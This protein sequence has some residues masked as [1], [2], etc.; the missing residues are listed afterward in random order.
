MRTNRSILSFLFSTRATKSIA[1]PRASALRFEPLET[2]ELLDAS[3]VISP[4]QPELICVASL[5][6]Q[7]YAPIDLS[8]VA[9]AEDYAASNATSGQT[10]TVTSTSAGATQGS[11]RYALNNAQDGDTITFASSLKGKTIKLTGTEFSVTKSV[12]IDASALYD[13]ETNT[14]GV[15]IDA[16]G[17]SRAFS[18]GAEVDEVTFKGLTVTN[19]YVLGNGGGVYSLAKESNFVNCVVKDNVAKT[20]SFVD[21]VS[22]ER[23]YAPGWGGGLY[24]TGTANVTNCIVIGNSCVGSERAGDQLGGGIMCDYYFIEGGDGSDWG[25]A[26]VTL[27]NSVIAGNKSG[28]GGAIYS[29][30]QKVRLVHCTISGNMS[31]VDDDAM[32][33]LDDD[34]EPILGSFGFTAVYPG[35]GY[36]IESSI[37][38]Q[39][40][41]GNLYDFSGEESGGYGGEDLSIERTVTN[42]VI[43]DDPSFVE[44]PVFIDGALTNLSTLDLHLS[45]SS[46][47]YSG[48]DGDYVG[49]YES[50]APTETETPS[51]VV[52]TALDVVD[53]TD[54]LVS[55]REAVEVYAN[56]GDT[57]TFDTSLAGGTI[58]LDGT[59]LTINKDLTVD[60]SALWN[61]EERT[62]GITISGASKS[63]VF[64]V[65]DA[66]HVAFVALTITN[67]R[68]SE[69]GGGVYIPTA[70]ASFAKCVISDSIASSAGGGV[71]LTGSSTFKDCTIVGNESWLDYG[72]GVY[73]TGVS[74]F[75][76]CVILANEAPY[77]GGGAYL[78]RPASFTNCTI[79]GNSCDY[80]LGGGVQLIDGGTFTRSIVALNYG[81]DVGGAYTQVGASYTNE[82]SVIAENPMFQVAPIIIGRKLF[83]GWGDPTHV[84]NRS[85]IDLNLATYS[86]YV[87]YL[88]DGYVG[89]YEF[90]GIKSDRPDFHI[91]TTLDDEFDL[92]NDVVSLREA[93]YMT[94]EDVEIVFAEGLSGVIKL[95]SEL[96][97]YSA[98]IDGDNRITLDGQSCSRVISSWGALKLRNMT[99]V[100]GN[101]DYG[102]GVMSGCS[103][104]F[105]NLVVKDCSGDNGGG[106]S[107]WNNSTAS[108]VNCAIVDN[109]S[110]FQSGGID[111]KEGSQVNFT[112]CT[113]ANNGTD[114]TNTDKYCGGV[115]VGAS[116]TVNIYNSIVTSELRRAGQQS[117]ANAYNTLSS[118]TDW[119]NQSTE[120]VVNY[121]FDE[122]APLFTD[123]ENGVFTLAQ[124]SQA[125]D[126]GNNSY[127]TWERDLL[128][129]P[130]IIG[131]SVDLGAYEMQTVSETPSTVVT[132]ALDVVDAT[133][134]L[135]SLREAVEV[136]ANAGDTITFAPELKGATI[137]LSGEELTVTKSITID[138]STLYDTETNTP[139]ATIDADGKSRVFYVDSSVGA[140]AI[141]GLSMINGY[142]TD[143]GGALCSDA[144]LTS[145]TNCIVRDNV[146][147]AVYYGLDEFN[148][149]DISLGRGGGLCFTGSANVTN[150]VILG[151]TTLSDTWTGELGEVVRNGTSGG[152]IIG[153]FNY[154]NIDYLDDTEP[155]AKGEHIINVTNC[156][157]AGNSSDGGGAISSRNQLVNLLHCTISG[158]TTRVEV[159][160]HTLE[161]T[162]VYLGGDGTVTSSIISQNQGGNLFDFS[163]VEATADYTPPK[164]TITSS[165]IDDDPGF[166]EAP[167][168]VDGALTNL[169]TL[170]LHLSPSSPYYNG[171]NGDYVGAYDTRGA[172]PTAAPE[173]PTNLVFGA[174]DLSTKRLPMSWTDNSS[175]ESGFVTQFSYDGL[176]W[177][178][179]GG[180]D[181]N[182]TSRVA[183]SIKAGQK[184]YFRV[185]A[186]N[187]YGQ[188]DWTYGEIATPSATPA[189]PSALTFANYSPQTKRV[190]MSWTDN[191]SD[192]TSFLVQYSVDGGAT[193]RNSA[194]LGANETERTATGIAENCVYQFRVAAR[195]VYGASDWAYGTFE[196]TSNVNPE[197]AAP[198]NLTFSDYLPTT[199]RVEM[200]WT[201]VAEDETGY[202]VQ[203]SVDGGFSWR[204]SAT[205]DAN[206]TG[207]TASSLAPDRTYRFR[208]AAQNASGVSAWLYGEFETSVQISANLAAPSD[209]TFSDYSSETRSVQMTWT[210]NAETEKGF[211]MQYSV[212][213]GAIWRDSATLGANV[214]SRVATSLKPNQEYRFRLAAYDGDG[215]SAWTY[216][217]FT[218]PSAIPAAPTNLAFSD[219]NASTRSVVM[220]W[221]DNATNESG[222]KVEYSVDGGATWRDSAYLGANVETR[223]ATGLVP[224]RRYGFRVAA[225]NEYGLS[226]WATNEFETPTS[227]SDAIL[228]SGSRRLIAAASTLD[229]ALAELFIDDEEFELLA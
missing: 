105:V 72:G 26:L 156:V 199:R 3:P 174:Y 176:N 172:A 147:H 120:G 153:D 123:A 49:A 200:S 184:Y 125:I 150:S 90:T 21:P 9:S 178:R 87:D 226:D 34:G 194:Y 145:I 51:T 42:S 193:W 161:G 169:A 162:A 76:N 65:S 138:A 63:R 16:S 209:L 30:N 79:T 7:A 24:L 73:S 62:P 134:G 48:L 102:G 56:A 101:G 2:R 15:T 38:S 154:D 92:S 185:A 167:V 106:V 201:D 39:N 219:Y 222:F 66:D 130:R 68:T 229:E 81:K 60:A 94:P 107:I 217:Q 18:V 181:A 103:G 71:Y 91:V 74:E 142:T 188:S 52:T 59:E 218:T 33:G 20:G 19:G 109:R 187:E 122:N 136:Y 158:N 95:D 98:N 179:G 97:A 223:V 210:D 86:P 23:E 14:P 164:P 55:L 186:F 197:L 129:E 191:S 133:D 204:T 148:L 203:Y 44:A 67:G 27:T 117:V 113:I 64:N 124:G 31:S 110:R 108:F 165:V 58:T 168:F 135:I 84:V 29:H 41:G 195:N 213:G 160:G 131:A 224:G 202:V 47:Y 69:K 17:Q 45:P 10:W 13:T 54:G 114:N 206:A 214:T 1:S 137:T 115:R 83:T 104:E 82:S 93:I 111:V 146:A 70:N 96:L 180:T 228:E 143:R 77:G 175:A 221:T 152:G 207:R 196:S 166:V 208:V 4:P 11:L 32:I 173:A 189:A 50:Q 132:T 80:Q 85:E 5:D 215:Y 99:I 155:N 6:A 227:A 182:V 171:L 36:T 225:R 118:F 139:G 75:T 211:V 205:L 35:A 177:N 220:T 57:I 192:E 121:V 100:N 183:T 53:A 144:E 141:T 149:P 212:D 157:I 198:T 46:P 116:A 216:G 127:T 37:I 190:E 119:T 22:G 12:T 126:K 163:Q 78:T 128:G 88:E 89:A 28:G 40:E 43:D 170:D 159:N 112:N 8:A 61:A 140:V 25:E 151:N